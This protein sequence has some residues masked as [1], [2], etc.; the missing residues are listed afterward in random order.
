[1]WGYGDEG[2]SFC[3]V[4]EEGYPIFGGKG[5]CK[6]FCLDTYVEVANSSVIFISTFKLSSLC[7]YFDHLISFLNFF[8]SFIQLQD[9]SSSWKPNMMSIKQCISSGSSNRCRITVK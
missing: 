2:Y 4:C 9:I 6:S 7:F 5:F 8:P 3:G 1:M